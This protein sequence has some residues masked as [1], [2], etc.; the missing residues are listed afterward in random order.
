MNK[1]LIVILIAVLAFLVTFSIS[2]SQPVYIEN[3]NYSVRDTIEGNAGWFRS[4]TSNNKAKIISPGLTY[5]GY[6]GSGKGNCVFIPNESSGEV[7]IMSV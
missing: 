7:Y 2:F 4:S 6:I 5:T 1:I 3:F